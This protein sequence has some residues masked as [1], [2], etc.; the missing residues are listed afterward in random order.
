MILFN[1]ELL[2]RSL[3]VFDSIASRHREALSLIFRSGIL[4]FRTFGL[5]LSCALWP[6]PYASHN[7]VSSTAQHI[8]CQTSL[9][10]SPSLP[11]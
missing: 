7:F 4:C 5:I 8:V 2:D 9:E 1:I 3:G 6:Q 11:R 10:M